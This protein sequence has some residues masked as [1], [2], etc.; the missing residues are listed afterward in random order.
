MSALFPANALFHPSSAPSYYKP[1]SPT[2]SAERGGAP[3]RTQKKTRPAVC[4]GTNC[5][6]SKKPGGSGGIGNVSG[7]GK[8]Q[9]S[10]DGPK[11]NPGVRNRAPVRAEIS[12]SKPQMESRKKKNEEE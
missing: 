2:I 1:N 9:C 7:L 6:I 10:R 3:Q 4:Q 12:P 11:E 5:A 8:Q